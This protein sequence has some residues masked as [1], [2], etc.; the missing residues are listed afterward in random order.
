MEA[1]RLAEREK[2]LREV[3]AERDNTAR[4][5]QNHI[6]ALMEKLRHKDTAIKVM[7]SYLVTVV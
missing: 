3:L 5:H 1:G 6:Q 2:L 7:V 4:D